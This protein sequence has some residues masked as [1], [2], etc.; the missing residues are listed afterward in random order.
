MYKSDVTTKIKSSDCEVFGKNDVF[1]DRSSY[2]RYCLT[3]SGRKGYSLTRLFFPQI[4]TVSFSKEFSCCS[5]RNKFRTGAVPRIFS[6]STE[7]FH[8]TRNYK[9][10]SSDH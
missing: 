3:C 5:A 2:F 4:R 1:F 6:H 10:L 7:H 9:N 8:L